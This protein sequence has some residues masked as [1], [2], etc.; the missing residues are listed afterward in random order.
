MHRQYWIDKYVGMPAVCFINRLT[1]IQLNSI[2]Y[3]FNH[4]TCFEYSGSEL[5][6]TKD[7]N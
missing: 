2:K 4:I 5:E 1:D 6:Q 7:V 3:Q